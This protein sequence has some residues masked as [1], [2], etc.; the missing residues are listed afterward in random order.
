MC[1]RDSSYDELRAYL[2][3]TCLFYLIGALGNLSN[4]YRSTQCQVWQID[5]A[6]MMLR[7][8]AI[9]VG[10]AQKEKEDKVSSSILRD[11]NSD[12]FPNHQGPPSKRRVGENKDSVQKERRPTL[13]DEVEQVQVNIRNNAFAKLHRNDMNMRQSIFAVRSTVKTSGSNISSSYE[14]RLDTETIAEAQK[15][16]AGILFQMIDVSDDNNI[17]EKEFYDALVTLGVLIPSHSF[18]ALYKAIDSDRDGLIQVSEFIDYVA[19]IKP[20][21]STRRRRLTTVSF[22]FSQISLYLIFVQIFAGS[23]QTHAASFGLS[24]INATKNLFVCK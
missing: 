11:N 22:M 23:A 1:I 2:V 20:G 14:G 21:L 3:A 6:R 15:I 13:E 8:A 18:S 5:D 12:P 16:G 9:V 10:L 7:E 24:T 4:L 19:K 17:D